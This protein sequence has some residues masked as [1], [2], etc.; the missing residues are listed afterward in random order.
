MLVIIAEKPFSSGDP[1][2]TIEVLPEEDG[3]K[4]RRKPEGFLE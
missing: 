4:E 1:I 2:L 3:K